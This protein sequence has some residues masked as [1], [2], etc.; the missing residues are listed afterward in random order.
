MSILTEVFAKIKNLSRM[1][2]FPT[3]S[4]YNNKRLS[5]SGDSMKMKGWNDTILAVKDVVIVA[6]GKYTN[7]DDIYTDDVYKKSYEKRNVFYNLK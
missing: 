3:K 6:V 4:V 5:G 1:L 7:S 2:A